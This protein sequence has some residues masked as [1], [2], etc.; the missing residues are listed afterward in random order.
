MANEY[1]LTDEAWAKIEP[2]I[3]M[4]RRGV[5]PANNRRAISGILHVLK[6]GCRWRDCPAVY[7]PHTT[8]YN[9]FNRWSKAGIWQEMFLR[10]RALDKVEAFS[11]DSTTSKAHRCSAG[12]KGGLKSRRSAAAEGADDQNPRRD[13]R[14]RSSDRLRSERRT[15]RRHQ[16]CDPPAGPAARAGSPAG[17]HRL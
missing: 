17:R 6:Y 10:I 4:G 13:R 15:G 3:P 9:R 11:I 16:V 14:G 2:S 7:G 1:W 8:I 5:K 12:G